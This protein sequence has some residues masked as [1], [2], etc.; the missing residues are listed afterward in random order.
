[1]C[2]CVYI[3]S[4]LSSVTFLVEVFFYMCNHFLITLEVGHATHWATVTPVLHTCG[5]LTRL[6]QTEV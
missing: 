4:N 5:S 3:Y 6:Q 2:V 1:V